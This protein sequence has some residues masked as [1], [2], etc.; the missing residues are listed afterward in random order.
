MEQAA[1]RRAVMAGAE[2]E[3]RLDL[4]RHIVGADARP[5]VAAMNEKAPGPDR[6][7]AGER[8]RH[9]VAPL[10]DPEG[11]RAAVASS[12]ATAMR[13]RTPSSSGAKPK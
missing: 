6:R 3:P 7:E 12:A 4:D 8:A 11:R 9:P 10:G 5:V 2:G 1:P 13:A